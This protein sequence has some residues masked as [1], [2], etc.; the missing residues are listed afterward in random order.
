MIGPKLTYPKAYN[1]FDK[2]DFIICNLGELEMLSTIIS[3]ALIGFGIQGWPSSGS[4]YIPAIQL[5]VALQ[6]TL[7]FI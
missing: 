1:S 3:P 5:I 6:A 7:P 2:S 4:M